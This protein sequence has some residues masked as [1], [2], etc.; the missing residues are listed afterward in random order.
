[1]WVNYDNL[2]VFYAGSIGV[3]LLLYAVKAGALH[4][5]R[6]TWL[7]CVAFGAAAAL[8]IPVTWALSPD[9]HNGHVARIGI[10]VGSPVITLV[11]PCVSFLADLFL[12]SVDLQDRWRRRVLFEWLVA[13]PAWFFVW[14]YFEAFFLGWVWI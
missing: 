1:M 2:W 7:S 13:V 5:V 8:C 3:I 12:G 14:I 10:Y 11:V 6:T 4:Y 9:W